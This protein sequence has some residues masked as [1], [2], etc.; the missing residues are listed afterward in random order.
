MYISS[1]ILTCM[2]KWL[3]HHPSTYR[4]S[5]HSMVWLYNMPNTHNMHIASKM[6][7]STCLSDQRSMQ[8][9]WD[10]LSK[11]TINFCDGICMSLPCTV[12]PI[13]GRF[14]IGQFIR[15]FS[16][17]RDVMCCRDHRTCPQLEGLNALCQ[18]PLHMQLCFGCTYVARMVIANLNGCMYRCIWIN[19]YMQLPFRHQIWCLHGGHYCMWSKL[20]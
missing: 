12:E 5:F 19:I 4:R 7:R 16:L 11:D 10:I 14:G 8:T 2:A 6:C 1:G 3:P 9:L 18:V 20:H 13:N 17:M 15:R